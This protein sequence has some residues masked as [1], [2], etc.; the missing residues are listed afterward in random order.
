M[1]HA[2]G[3]V[4]SG[5]GFSCA[6]H[7][8]TTSASLNLV[9][10]PRIGIQGYLAHKKP[11]P[12]WD[13]HRALG[14]C[15]LWGPRGALFVM[16]EVPLTAHKGAFCVLALSESG[17]LIQS[18]QTRAPHIRQSV[19]KG[20]Q[21]SICPW[22]LRLS[23]VETVFKHG[24]EAIYPLHQSGVANTPPPPST[25]LLARKF[26]PCQ[27]NGFKEEPSVAEAELLIHPKL[28]SESG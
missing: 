17:R 12:L 13:H 25:A 20:C 7:P 9:I 4:L 23:K 14:I 6:S 21:K 15:L 26:H 11:P 18:I 3:G 16:S 8:C 1:A 27:W 19:E 2:C 22:A 24:F 10:L 5:C 28:M